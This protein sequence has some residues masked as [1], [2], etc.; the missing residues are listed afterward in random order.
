MGLLCIIHERAIYVNEK[1]WSNK[2]KRLK[3]T[4]NEKKIFLTFDQT[5]LDFSYL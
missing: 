5:Y 3:S 2:F 4:L 1:E